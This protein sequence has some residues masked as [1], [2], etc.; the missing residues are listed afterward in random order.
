MPKSL[1]RIQVLWDGIFV[2][3]LLA[4]AALS[5]SCCHETTTTPPTPV[6]VTSLGTFEGSGGIRYSANISA[7]TQ[8]TLSFKSSG[9]ADNIAQR[10]GAS[11][12]IPVF[13]LGRP[14]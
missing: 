12:P 10:T 5:S 14:G 4:V 9:Y 11:G 8:V 3:A 2:L 6:R 7:F 13:P 1:K